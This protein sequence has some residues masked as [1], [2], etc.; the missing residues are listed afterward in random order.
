M[1]PFV[2]QEITVEELL[3][4]K[5]PYLLCK[6]VDGKKDFHFMYEIHHLESE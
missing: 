4:I 2:L 3:A 6:A 5:C 1:G